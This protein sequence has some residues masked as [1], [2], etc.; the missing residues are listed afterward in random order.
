MAR[1]ALVALAGLLSVFA[2]TARA[3]TVVGSSVEWLTCASDVVVAGRVE[4][5]VT[6]R[7]AGDVF[8]DDCTIVVQEVIK[9]KVEGDRLVFCLRTLS[10]ESA[11]KAWMKSREP[12][13]LFL[14]KSVGHGSEKHLDNMLVPTSH[15]VPLSVID[16]AAPGKF[17][18][19]TRFK[20]LTD[21][22]V[23]LDTCRK[24]AEQLA[25][26]LKQNPGGNV[27]AAQLEVPP[28]SEAWGSLYAG[29]ACFINAPAFGPIKQK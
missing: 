2:I 9:G 17:V 1:S 11:A 10:A 21:K 13:L 15:Q 12:I 6:T 25:E 5:I 22:K 23:I 7:G 29:S 28:S 8:Y 18:L 3:E 27:T 19:D 20:V 14:S 16:L 4:R 24:A 26:H